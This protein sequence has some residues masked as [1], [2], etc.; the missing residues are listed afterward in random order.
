MPLPSRHPPCRNGSCQSTP[1][2]GH[3][4]PSVARLHPAAAPHR[5]GP[6]TVARGITTHPRATCF[7]GD[8][9][10][11]R[12]APPQLESPAHLAESPT[13]RRATP[14]SQPPTDLARVSPGLPAPRRPPS[15][16]CPNAVSGLPTPRP[17]CPAPPPDP[18]PRRPPSVTRRTAAL[19]T[20]GGRWYNCRSFDSRGRIQPPPPPE[21]ATGCVAGGEEVRIRRRMV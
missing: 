4:R 10:H 12:R 2:G 17:P 13:G 1:V 21:P 6:P 20:R 3:A 5:A 16:P 15:A 9:L 18:A 8:V 14:P 19:L 7:P 11:P